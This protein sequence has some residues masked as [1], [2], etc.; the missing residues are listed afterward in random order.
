MIGSR[1]IQGGKIVEWLKDKK[2]IM[3]YTLDKKCMY[4][5]DHIEQENDWL[6][7]F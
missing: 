6:Q 4:V 1:C 7:R 3:F 5:Y 2:V